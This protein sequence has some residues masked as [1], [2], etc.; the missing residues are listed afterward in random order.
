VL[1]KRAVTPDASRT[2]ELYYDANGKYPS[3]GTFAA[4]VTTANLV[5][6]GYI[7]TIPNDPS[8]GSNSYGFVAL[9]ASCDNSATICSSY[10]LGA[11]LETAGH[12]ALSSDSDAA[13]AITINGSATD[14]SANAGLS[15]EV[16]YCVK[17]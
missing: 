13:Q 7:S 5:T 3:G 16:V 12:S 11:I 9:P 6:P 2:L 4:G 8:G 10:A 14:C 17:P 15:S 1:E